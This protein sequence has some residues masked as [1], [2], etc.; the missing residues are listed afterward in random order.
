[1]HTWRAA[2]ILSSTRSFFTFS[3]S[4]ELSE[5][6]KLK[7]N[8]SSRFEPDTPSPH[9]HSPHTSLSHHPLSLLFASLP[10]LVFLSWLSLHSISNA[11]SAEIFFWISTHT[12]RI[13]GETCQPDET[14]HL[15]QPRSGPPC[16][17]SEC[18][19]SRTPVSDSGNGLGCLWVC[20][21]G[22]V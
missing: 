12:L 21:V 14:T 7:L 3:T 6:T 13:G 8:Y 18:S 4:A 15:P 10:S 17:M 9:I 1:M 19:P 20:P 11:Y 5:S 16:H 22:A 2:T